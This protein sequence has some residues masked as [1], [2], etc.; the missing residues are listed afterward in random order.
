[1]DFPICIV[2]ISMG[3]R[4]VY[5]KGSHVEFSKLY[6][7]NFDKH[8]YKDFHRAQCAEPTFVTG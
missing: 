7:S 5:F 8:H 4:I 3:V 2:T 1:M 6:Y